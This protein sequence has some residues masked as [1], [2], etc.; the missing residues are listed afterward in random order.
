MKAGDVVLAPLPHRI[1]VEWSEEDEAYVARV[2]ALNA[3]AHGDTPE[4]ATREAVVAAQ[5]IL[6]SVAE[7]RQK[8]SRDV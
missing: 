4:E 7:E 3:A 2:P 1:I 8:T 6:E 5:G